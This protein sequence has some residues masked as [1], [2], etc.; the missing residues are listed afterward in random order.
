VVLILAKLLKHREGAK[1]ELTFQELSFAFCHKDRQWSHNY[2]REF[3][4]CGGDILSFL[5]RENKLEELAFDLIEQQILKTPLLPLPEQYAMFRDTYPEI[6]LSKHTFYKYVSRI[7]S[8][9]VLTRVR[10]LLARGDVE[11]NS[12]AYIKERIVRDP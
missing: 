8:C 12:R 6:C 1:T 3:E 7:N 4:A 10:E 5:R 2:Y 9:K 11:P